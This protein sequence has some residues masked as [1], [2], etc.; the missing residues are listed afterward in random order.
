M[1]TAITTEF[2]Q[3][4]QATQWSAEAENA[5]MRGNMKEASILHAKAGELLE[6]E[7]AKTSNPTDQATICFLAATQFYLGGHYTKAA[8]SIRKIKVARLPDNVRMLHTRFERDIRERATPAYKQMILDRILRY[9]EN[10]EYQQILDLLKEHYYVVEDWRLAFFR[11][12][13]CQNLRDYKAAAIFNA[14][15]VR[16]WPSPD[17]LLTIAVW[18]LR[19]AGENKLNDARE[20]A[21]LLRTHLP[22]PLIGFS[23][24]LVLDTIASVAETHQKRASLREE[25]LQALKQAENDFSR[26]P[27]LDQ[28]DRNHREFVVLAIAA[29]ARAHHELGDPKSEAAA[30]NRAVDFDPNVSFSRIVR[31]YFN[32]PSPQAIDDFR[33]AI[34]L[35]HQDYVPFAFLAEDA[36]TRQD[37]SSA[38]KWIIQAIEL[39]PPFEVEAQLRHYLAIATRNAEQI[40]ESAS[41][42]DSSVR[43]PNAFE[44][45]DQTNGKNGLRIEDPLVTRMRITQNRFKMQFA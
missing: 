42:S 24:S 6:I 18:P 17:L 15:A 30:I 44:L 4:G 28:S 12:Q 34:E 32:Y 33:K 5:R 41:A 29:S 27:A 35:G 20:F 36:I 9:R 45:R 38:R 11:A 1:I 3:T 13:C 8:R 26:L 31:G 21:Q 39:N 7:A 16:H 2:N 10:G 40:S 37:N 25:Q 23:A 43:S 22:H 19:L 14:D